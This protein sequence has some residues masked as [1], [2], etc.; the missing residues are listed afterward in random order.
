MMQNLIAE[1]FRHGLEEADRR[2]RIDTW[3]DREPTLHRRAS[4]GA[5]VRALV[6]SIVRS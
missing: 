6:A 1:R 3:R 2:P 5:Y 4:P